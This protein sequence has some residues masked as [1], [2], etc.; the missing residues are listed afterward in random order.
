[1]Q[2]E[3]HFRKAEA[4]AVDR[5]ARLAGQRHFKAAAEAETVD[6]GHRRNL[7][8]LEPVDHR[9][10]PADRGLDRTGVR[11]AAKFV[12]IGT[13]DE[14]GR[15]GGTNDDAGG[16]LVFQRSEHEIEFLEHIG[17]QRVGAGAVAVEQ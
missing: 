11:R 3:H 13:G 7:Q 2:A 16:P 4:R 12:D 5:N 6:H 14:A 8:G 17:R 1:M 10:G 15:L 9:M